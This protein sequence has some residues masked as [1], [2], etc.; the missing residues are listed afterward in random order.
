ITLQM[1]F[2]GDTTTTSYGWD[3][4]MATSG[5]GTF[6]GWVATT[7]YANGMTSVS[8][9][10][11]QGRLTSKTDLGGHVTSAGYDLAGRMTSRTTT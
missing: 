3:G 1:A 10:D 4:A 8:R 2:G 7:S 9:T 5:L 11:F 6:G